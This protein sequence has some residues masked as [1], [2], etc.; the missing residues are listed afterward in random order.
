MKAFLLA[1]S[2]VTAV[3]LATTSASAEVTSRNDRATI[4][5]PALANFRVEDLVA[6]HH[7]TWL[8]SSVAFALSAFVTP[9][10]SSFPVFA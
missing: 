4:D 7:A 3:W 10:A 2:Y 5:K 9:K 8:Q 6:E 1:P